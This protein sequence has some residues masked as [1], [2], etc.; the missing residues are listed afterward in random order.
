MVRGPRVPAVIYV[1]TISGKRPFTGPARIS[2]FISAV[3]IKMLDRVGLGF[4]KIFRSWSG[5]TF[6]IFSPGPVWFRSLDPWTEQAYRDMFPSHQNYFHRICGSLSERQWPVDWF[7]G[8]STFEKNPKS[9]WSWSGKQIKSGSHWYSSHSHPENFQ[10]VV[11]W[12]QV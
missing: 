10:S 11:N 3:S 2:I 8:T 1:S 6:L 4:W 5:Q 9:D 12:S 7:S